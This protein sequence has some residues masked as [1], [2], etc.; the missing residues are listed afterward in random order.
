MGKPLNKK[1]NFISNIIFSV[2]IVCLILGMFFLTFSIFKTLEEMRAIEECNSTPGCMYC[3]PTWVNNKEIIF[4]G[5]G[6]LLLVVAITLF[7][8]FIIRRK[9]RETVC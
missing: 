6:I 9:K 8:I 3:L 1:E 7:I 5:F 4:N 2:S